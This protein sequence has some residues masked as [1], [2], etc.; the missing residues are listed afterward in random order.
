MF[1]RLLTVSLLAFTMNVQAQEENVQPLDTLT[2]HVAGIKADLEVLKRIK[3]SGYVQAQFQYADSSG[4][5]SFAG[6][7]FASG[8]DKRLMVR[9]GRLKVQYLSPVT[10][11]GT[12]TSEYVFQM[13]MTERGLTIK[14]AFVRI[15]EP[16]TGWF[17][18][19]AGVFDRPFGHEIAYSS[20]LRES[21]ERGRMSQIVFPNERDMGAMLSIGGPKNSRWNWLRL[22]LALV[23]GTGAPGVGAN[24][25]DFD[26][27]KDFIGHLVINRSSK[28]ELIKYGLGASIYDGG[29]RHDVS[30]TYKYGTDAAGVNGFVIDV[31]K[32][33]VPSNINYR[34]II[35]RQYVGFDAQLSV[36]WLAGLTTIRAEYIQGAQPGTS[37]SS[38]SL[39]ASPTSTTTTTTNYIVVD[40]SGAPKT[41]TTTSTSTAASDLYTR[42]F[43]GAYFYFI[44]NIGSLPLQAIVKYDWYD[45]NT[46]L[47]GDE[48]GKAVTGTD[49]KKSGEADIK[50][51]T[52][53]L[54]LAYRFSENVK[55][56][57]YY[58]MVENEKTPN[59]TATGG[60]NYGS[61]LKDNIFTFRM[62]VKF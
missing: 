27:K 1:K 47:T 25:S 45:P 17:S 60:P 43:N 58:D 50:Y 2:S 24:T 38:A 32:A 5:S 48:I 7:N 19:K 8:V 12:N 37:S 35:K 15:T 21:P 46:D 10:D 49:Y 33:D 52:L 29:Y 51:T 55:F 14:D 22:D 4:Q 34:P 26:K 13:D 11:K 41:I 20:S 23:N 42:N 40:T 3:V 57:A 6:G 54:G 9:R 53:G 61:D 31:K 44:Q 28:N 56:T 39:A 30:N 62:Q 59:V 18:L 36:D 16:W